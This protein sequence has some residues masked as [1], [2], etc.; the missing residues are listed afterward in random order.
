MVQEYKKLSQSFEEVKAEKESCSHKAEL[1]SSSE[2]QAALSMLATENDDL[3]SRSE[4]MLNENQRLAGIISSWTR[5]STSLDKLHGAM[6]PS[7]DKTELDY[8]GS[9]SS[10][11]ETSYN[12]QLSR[13]K[14]QTM[15]FVKS[16]T[17]QPVEAQFVEEKITAKPPIW[18]GRFCGLGYT[19]TEK[20]R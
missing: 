7:G 12:P 2:M 4:E 3:R 11:A 17:G 9:D 19:A 10:I 1:V 16:S 15:N 8:D 18:Q 13:T 14:L 5:S 6:K 20:S